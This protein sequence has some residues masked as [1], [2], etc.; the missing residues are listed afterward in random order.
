MF[1][2]AASNRLDEQIFVNFGT[3]QNKWWINKP[4]CI[5]STYFCDLVRKVQ[6]LEIIQLLHD[7]VL[8][9]EVLLGTF[10]KKAQ[11]E[12]QVNFLKGLTV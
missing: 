11:K 10:A 4:F 5:K 3:L 7:P 12:I 8:S 2:K 9:S 1:N 6:L